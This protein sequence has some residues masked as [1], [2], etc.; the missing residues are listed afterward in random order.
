MDSKVSQ[1]DRAEV[2]GRVPLRTE[3]FQR[4]HHDDSTIKTMYKDADGKTMHAYGRTISIFEHQMH[5]GA[6]APK[7]VFAEC[8]WFDDHGVNPV[9]KLPVVKMP[10]A[11]DAA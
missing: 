6:D 10:D 1:Y 5:T 8:M 3:S 11:G 2:N 9:S 4:G 7:V